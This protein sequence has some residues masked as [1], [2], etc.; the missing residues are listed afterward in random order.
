MMERILYAA[1]TFYILVSIVG[2]IKDPS[3]AGGVIK[4]SHMTCPCCDDNFPPDSKKEMSPT[5]Y[6]KVDRTP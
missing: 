5:R 6:T 3:S 4:I 1:I 2:L